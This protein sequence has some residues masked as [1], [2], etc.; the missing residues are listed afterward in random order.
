MAIIGA[1]ATPGRV[2]HT[3]V[4]NLI[5]GGFKGKIYPVN[6]RLSEVEGLKAFP[7]VKEL[8]EKPDLALIGIQPVAV[9]G[10]LKECAM[11]GIKAAIIYTSGFAEAGPEGKRAQQE[12][13]EIAQEYGIRVIGPNTQGVLN[14]KDGFC[15]LSINARD[16]L[17]QPGPVSFICQSALFPWEYALRNPAIGL[18]KM[19]D[20]G[21][22]CDLDHAD[23]L[24]VL[25]EDPETKIIV[26][27]IEG[28]KNSGRLRQVALRVTS[29]KPVLA[30][31]VGRTP[32]GSKAVASHTGSLA[33][34]AEMYE[35][36][37]RQT[38]IY[39]LNDMDD[40]E[41]VTRALTCLPPVRGKRVGILTTTGAGGAMAADACEQAGLEIARLS[42]ETIARI[43]EFQPPWVQI[44]NP[45]DVWQVLDPER[46]KPSFLAAWE[47]LDNAPEVDAVFII[48]HMI[49]VIP[50][51]NL[52]DILL[53]MAEKGVRKPTVMWPFL[54][55]KNREHLHRLTIKGVVPFPTMERTARALAIAYEFRDKIAR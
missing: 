21:N 33:G 43:K 22:M 52:L 19:I 17:G 35:A 41:D 25:G 15:G 38:G 24:E 42:G 47:A 10:V 32:G 1:S 29:R 39:Q 2:G 16:L 20:L 49:S 48:A 40:L 12:L 11:A 4:V 27:E 44:G 7:E 18:G 6:P 45:V 31:K 36:F 3:L 46:L 5:F 14:I 28:I 9:P 13:S 26:M 30:L 50:E 54:D 37:F 23:S 34:S 8:P 53:R 51:F 55:D